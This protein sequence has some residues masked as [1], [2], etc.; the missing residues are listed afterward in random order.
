MK[1]DGFAIICLPAFDFILMAI[2]TTRERIAPT[3]FPLVFV[4]VTTPILGNPSTTTTDTASPY[5]RFNS[6]NVS[7]FVWITLDSFE[8]ILFTRNEWS[9]FL[10]INVSIRF[11]VV[12]Y[13]EFGYNKDTTRYNCHYWRLG[14]SSFACLHH[15]WLR[16]WRVGGWGLLYKGIATSLTQP[17]SSLM[18]VR[19]TGMQQHTITSA[20]T[21]VLRFQLAFWAHQPPAGD[22]TYL[23]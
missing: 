15:F 5:K 23:G 8:L 19:K 13:N 11:K 1:I 21:F 9:P 22:Q 14:S 16:M 6:R 2:Y 7:G 17:T 18:E 10:H 3:I 4:T 12:I 20:A